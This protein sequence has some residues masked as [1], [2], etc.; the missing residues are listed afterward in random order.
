VTLF[1]E[2]NGRE[3]ISEVASRERRLKSAILVNQCR[4]WAFAPRC[5]VFVF[6][7]ET[8]FLTELMV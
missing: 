6:V 5:L 8:T 7:F 1:P 2:I 4:L 3:V